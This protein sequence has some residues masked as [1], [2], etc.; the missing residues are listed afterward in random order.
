MGKIKRILG[1]LSLIFLLLATGC[2]DRK[3][4]EDTGIVLGL[5]IDKPE[6]MKTEEHQPK[7]HRISL[8]HQFAVPDPFSA[9][10]GGG[11]KGN[12]VNMV[13]ESS[14]IFAGIR[15]LATQSERAPSYEHLQVLVI[16]EDIARSIDLNEIINFLMRNTESRRTIKVVIAKGQSREV[17]EKPPSI[18]QIPVLKL[19][20]LIQHTRKTLRMA[21]DLNLGD[22]SEKITAKRSFV[23]QRV[24]TSKKGVKISG[25]A[26]IKG[27][28]AKMV[29]WLG[30]EETEGLNWL[31]GKG[32]AGLIEGVDPETGEPIVYEVREMKSQIKPHVRGGRISYTVEISTEGKLRED[33]VIPGNAFEQEFIKKAEKATEKEIKRLAEKAFT[34]TQKDFKVDVAGF[35]KK[36]SIQYP[37]VWK[38]VKK[39]WDSEFSEVPVDIKVKVQIREYGTRG[40]KSG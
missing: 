31:S 18:E 30:E 14:S 11:A 21:P 40:T 8:V 39:D 36:L 7:R 29:G 9:K 35:G 27:K 19:H 38:D 5:G 15:E 17:F 34:K 28:S 3:E 26:I 20:D 25:A 24:V 13:N 12:Y 4:I 6:T 32:K 37:Q 23:V 2:W 16:S 33:W 10:E 1:W 22:F